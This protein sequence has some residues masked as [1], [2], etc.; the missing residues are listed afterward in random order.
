VWWMTC[1]DG[2]LYSVQVE[3]L[4]RMGNR[5]YQDDY[6]LCTIAR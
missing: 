1:K 5:S 4:H 6:A 2:H 3:D